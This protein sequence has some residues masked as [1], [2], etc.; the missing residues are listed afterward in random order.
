M[1][2][3]LNGGGRFEEGNSKDWPRG[4]TGAGGSR[5]GW[6]SFQVFEV[7]DVKSRNFMVSLFPLFV[8]IQHRS[9]SKR[10]ENIYALRKKQKQLQVGQNNLIHCHGKSA[11]MLWDKGC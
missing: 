2:R 6:P 8:V 4:G 11:S 1:S 5:W 7:V 3:S 10:M 9:L